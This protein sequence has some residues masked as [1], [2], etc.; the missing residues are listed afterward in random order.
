MSPGASGS[1]AAARRISCCDSVTVRPSSFTNAAAALISSG[2]V[3]PVTF[4]ARTGTYNESAI[5]ITSITGASSAN[6]I[7]FQSESGVSSDVTLKTGI[8]LDACSFITFNNLTI[9]PAGIVMSNETISG[10]G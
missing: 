9:G 3:G 7:T 6:T 8:T 2:I 5:N 4:A 1:Q 10:L